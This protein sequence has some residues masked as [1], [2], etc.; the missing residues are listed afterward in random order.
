MAGPFDAPVSS[1]RPSTAGGDRRPGRCRFQP[2]KP[3]A[4]Q[5]MQTRY[6]HPQWLWRPALTYL[7]PMT[8]VMQTRPA[9][10]IAGAWSWRRAEGT[11]NNPLGVEKQQASGHRLLNKAWPISATSPSARVS[12]RSRL[13]CF[14]S[15]SLPTQGAE[16]QLID[17]L[18][19][20]R[21]VLWKKLP[22]TWEWSSRMLGL[23]PLP[24]VDAR[25]LGA[26]P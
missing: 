10:L 6:S 7:T 19:G 26:N 14:R 20:R 18:V 3:V 2:S 16:K 4:R 11:V 22:Y 8:P 1:W 12:A 13:R 24:F 25:R 17:A 21:V 9:T 23:R 15:D 5:K